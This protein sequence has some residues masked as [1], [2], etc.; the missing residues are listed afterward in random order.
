M[1]YERIKHLFVTFCPAL[2]LLMY[3]WV[4]W[5]CKRNVVRV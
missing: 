2:Y 5:S 4:A 1:G 3:I